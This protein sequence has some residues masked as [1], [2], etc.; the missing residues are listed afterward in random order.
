MTVEQRQIIE[1]PFNL[2]EGVEH[3]PAIVLSSNDAIETEN[4][5]VCVMLTSHLHNDEFSFSIENNMLNKPMDKPS[6]ARVHLISF[7][8]V[9]EITTNTHVN[10]FIKAPFFKELVLCIIENTFSVQID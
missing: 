4:A 6:E 2:P 9:N 3:H 5:F 10:H 1:V 7:F 8:K